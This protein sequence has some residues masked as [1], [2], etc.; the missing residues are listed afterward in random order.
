MNGG[1][2]KQP[3]FWTGPQRKQAANSWHR[4]V[5][6]MSGRRSERFCLSVASACVCVCACG[7]PVASADTSCSCAQCSQSTAWRVQRALGTD[8][9]EARRNSGVSMFLFFF[10]SLFFF[11]YHIAASLPHWPKSNRHKYIST[12]TRF[13]TVQ[14]RWLKLC[15]GEWC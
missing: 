5:I 14:P 1:A 15:E 9:Q 6:M 12:N 7:W 10:P 11:S 4:L 2:K 13:R 3:D 8:W